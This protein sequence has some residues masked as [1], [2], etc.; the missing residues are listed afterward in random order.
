MIGR[1]MPMSQR[2]PERMARSI[3]E[4]WGNAAEPVRLHKIRATPLFLRLLQQGAFHRISRPAR[5]F[6]DRICQHMNGL[7]PHCDSF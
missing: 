7:S 1:G 3:L 6:A 5:S 4:L 2:S